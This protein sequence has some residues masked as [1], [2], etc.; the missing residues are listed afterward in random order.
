MH[1]DLW[2]FPTWTA[3]RAGLLF[4]PALCIG[5]PLLLR[6]TS[7]LSL[8]NNT[9]VDPEKAAKRKNIF[10]NLH[11]DLQIVFAVS[12]PYLQYLAAEIAFGRRLQVPATFVRALV[13]I[14]VG[15]SAASW[16]GSTNV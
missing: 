11:S 3:P 7:S 8:K 13:G 15:L 5:I 12:L 1:F 4:Y 2:G 6:S 14:I 16:W 9:N 10:S